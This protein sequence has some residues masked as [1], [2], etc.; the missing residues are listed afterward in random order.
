MENKDF[1]SVGIM[2]KYLAVYPIDHHIRA[3]KDLI[4]AFID[5]GIPEFLPY[6]EK[7]IL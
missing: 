3:I 4:P 6:L 1:K 2:L 7:R 5:K